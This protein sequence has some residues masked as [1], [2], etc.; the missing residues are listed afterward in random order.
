MAAG[1]PWPVEYGP[2]LSRGFRSLK[3][4][5]Q[6]SEHGTDKLGAMMTQ[7]CEQAAYLAGLVQAQDTLQLLAP[8]A[9]NICCFRYVATDQSDQE[10]DAFNNEI[11]IQLQLSGIAAPSTTVL[12]GVTAIRVNLTNHRTQI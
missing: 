4:W 7:N 11:V 6:L 9:T 12:R 1:N 3:I 8:V 5:A 10:L 2:E